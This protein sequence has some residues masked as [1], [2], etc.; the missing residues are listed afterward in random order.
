MLNEGEGDNEPGAILAKEKTFPALPKPPP[1]KLVLGGTTLPPTK[2][3]FPGLL[4]SEPPNP[5]AAVAYGLAT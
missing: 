1:K 4:A 2:D 3:K 5:V